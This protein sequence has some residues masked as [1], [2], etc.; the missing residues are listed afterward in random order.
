MED[1]EL[2][3]TLFRAIILYFILLTKPFIP[4]LLAFTMCIVKCSFQSYIV[5]VE[6]LVKLERKER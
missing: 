4:I 1:E 6:L 5:E 3:K 2:Q